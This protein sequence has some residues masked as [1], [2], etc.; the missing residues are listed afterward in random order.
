[1]G[2]AYLTSDFFNRDLWIIIT[3][4]ARCKTLRADIIL[5]SSL[6]FVSL[7]LYFFVVLSRTSGSVAVVRLNGKELAKIDMRK[8][9]IYTLNDGTNEVTVK[10]GKVFMSYADCPD[11]ICIGMGEIRYTGECITCL[12]NRM[13][14]TVEFQ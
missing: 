14:V 2:K 8:D 12:P 3:V 4:M 13:T 9:G 11:K 5:V 6:L 10:D 1:M 7:V